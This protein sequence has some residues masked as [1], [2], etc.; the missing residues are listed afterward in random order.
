MFRKQRSLSLK[1]NR[2]LKTRN[3]NAEIVIVNYDKN[4]TVV[5]NH[6]S[7]NKFFIS[8]T[9]QITQKLPRTSDNPSKNNAVVA[10]DLLT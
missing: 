10:I 6:F 3:K 7:V 1:S 5:P 8:E 4:K 9:K 2:K